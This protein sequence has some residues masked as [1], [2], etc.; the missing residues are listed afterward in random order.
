MVQ[1]NVREPASAAADINGHASRHIES[2]LLNGM[3]KFH[4]SAR[5]PWVRLLALEAKWGVLRNF[6]AGTVYSSAVVRND[7]SCHD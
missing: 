6:G 2:E 4:P 3:V 1:K 7:C 5:H